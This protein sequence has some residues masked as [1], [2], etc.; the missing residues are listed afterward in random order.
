MD[1]GGQGGEPGQPG[2]AAPLTPEL[3]ADLQAGLL[4]NATAARLRRRA[5]S[6]PEAARVLAALDRVRRDLADLGADD[7]S[8]P[9]V[10]A[11]V[12]ARIGA[13]V[14]HAPPPRHRVV[15]FTRRTAAHSARH[16]VPRLQVVGALAGLCAAVA[17][18]GIGVAMLTHTPERT[19]PAGPT[20]D[21][22][23]VSASPRADVPLSD[24]QIVGLLTVRPDF[25]P[26][27]D[28]T[29]RTSC[30]GGLGYPAATK[31]LGARTVE[32]NGRP[33]VLMVLPGDN[34]QAL[35]AVVVTPDCSSADTGLLADKV[36]TRP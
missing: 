17:G 4:D 5:R 27:A 10:P 22:I 11:E 19:A 29:K 31:V 14:Q 3:L 36:V 6:D 20:A 28:P 25:G 7:S 16:A 1:S 30:L 35:V 12:T 8:A 13:A 2:S 34:P 9:D 32:M 23:T 26:L 24:P 15:G 18:V 21:R 33:G